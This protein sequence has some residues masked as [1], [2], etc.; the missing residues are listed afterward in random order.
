MYTKIKRKNKGDHMKCKYTNKQI[1][2]LSVIAVLFVI[3]FCQ[4]LPREVPEVPYKID[5]Q[6]EAKYKVTNPID[7]NA[8]KEMNDDVYALIYSKGANIEYPILQHPNDNLY[9]LNH[10]IDGVESY[11]ASIY[12][13]I[14]NAKDFNDSNT[15]IYGHNDNITGSMFNR[16]TNF[17]D[18]DFFDQNKYVYI[19]TPTEVLEYE[20]FASYVYDDRHILAS[21]DFANPD[22]FQNYIS[23]VLAREE[24][25]IRSDTVIKAEDKIITLSTCDF[26]NVGRILV[27]AVLK[28][29]VEC[30]AGS[31]VEVDTALMDAKVVEVSTK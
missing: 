18:K 20:V 4:M 8:L 7:F 27:Q 2:A 17:L 23:E 31:E 5:S 26:D 19:Y 6:I 15:L 22:I 13:E 28:N 25:T 24:S 12:T 10:M 21:F 11:P 30:P 14:E 16:M 29:R 3:I 9:Y 1:F